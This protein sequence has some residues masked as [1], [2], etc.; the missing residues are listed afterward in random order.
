[1]NLLQ[2]FLLTLCAKTFLKNKN[3]NTLIIDT[4]ELVREEYLAK[5]WLELLWF[6]V[7]LRSVGFVKSY[8]GKK[9]FLKLVKEFDMQR[10]NLILRDLN[11]DDLS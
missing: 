6:P 5:E 11:F 4:K 10:K 9:N 8:L 2:Y 1:M 3:K 7:K